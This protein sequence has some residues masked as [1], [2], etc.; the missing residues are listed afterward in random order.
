V[1]RGH[2]SLGVVELFERLAG[3]AVAHGSR[4]VAL[5]GN[6]CLMNLQVGGC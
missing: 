6:H 4:V 5:L 2:D 3:E 1:D